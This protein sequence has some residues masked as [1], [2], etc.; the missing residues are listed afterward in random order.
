MA[1]DGF[2]VVMEGRKFSQVCKQ[3][4][5]GKAVG[6]RA[7]GDVAFPLPHLPTEDDNTDF[8][9]PGRSLR[10]SN[11]D[12]S[13]PEWSNLLR[14]GSLTHYFLLGKRRRWISHVYNKSAM[15]NWALRHDQLG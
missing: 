14:R 5:L 1:D 15:V 2:S 8:A 6:G 3:A 13:L 9:R 7:K 4:E 11:L 12:L 10:V